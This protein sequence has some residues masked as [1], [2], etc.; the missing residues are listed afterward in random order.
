M[1]IFL[2]SP[3]HAQ[4][5]DDSIEKIAVFGSRIARTDSLGIAP[6]QVISADDIAQA[7]YIDIDSVLLELPANTGITLNNQ[8]NLGTT[9]SAS[10]V[11]LRGLGENLTLVL[12]NGLRVP[13]YSSAN[14]TQNFVNTSGIPTDALS[15][16]EVLT[17]GASAIYGSD[18]VSGVV[19]FVTNADFEGT[20]FNARHEITDDGGR[21]KTNLSV[22]YGFK[23][24]SNSTIVS[25]SYRKRAKLK[26]TDRLEYGL[27]EDTANGG[28]YSSFAAEVRDRNR[29]YVDSTRT[30]P[31]EGECFALLGEAGRYVDTLAS[32]R[33]TSIRCRFN[34]A[35]F[36]TIYPDTEQL[37]ISLNNTYEINDNWNFKTF[38]TYFQ[39]DTQQ[40]QEPKGMS[41]TVYQDGTNPENFSFDAD[42]F[43][44]TNRFSFRRRFVE[45][46]L[47]G[48]FIDDKQ[49]I[50]QNT[51]A[52]SIGD[53]LFDITYN[54]GRG[55]VDRNSPQVTF[56]G[57]EEILTFDPN[58]QDPAK[59]YPLNPISTEQFN[60]IS[61]RS[62]QK[63]FSELHQIQSVFTGD[64]P[65]NLGDEP[66]GFAI[67]A[68]IVDQ[69]FFDKKDFDTVNNGFVGFSS[70]QG[71]GG[72]TLYAIGAEFAIPISESVEFNLAG[73]YDYYDDATNVGGAFSPQVGFKYQPNSTFLLRANYTESFK[74][75]DLQRVHAG[76]TRLTSSISDNVLATFEPNNPNSSDSFRRVT[77]GTTDIKEE[78]SRSIVI[79]AVYA[80]TKNLEFTADYYNIKIDDAVITIDP[81]RI[82]LDPNNDLT[83]Q[84]SNCDEI[85]RV[86]F[87]T[88]LETEDDG[89]T[90][91]NLFQVC[92]GSVNATSRKA[93]GVDFTGRYSVLDTSAGDF[94]LS[95][96]TTWV[97]E[98]SQK[99]FSDSSLIEGTEVSYVPEWKSV[100]TLRWDH[101]NMGASLIWNHWGEAK[102]RN[103]NDLTADPYNPL[104][105]W[106]RVNFSA[107]YETDDLGKFTLGA[108]NILDSAPPKLDPEDSTSFP[109]YS[110][111]NGY[112]V[113]GRSFYLGYSLT[114]N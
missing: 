65:F 63:A 75:P 6:V 79:G 90:Y 13:L 40:D 64:L 18:A 34:R 71:G 44:S 24:D 70:T 59:W 28:N 54:Y 66:I 87:I 86:G 33:S 101:D 3:I 42:D 96:K 73:R 11:N 82:V 10:G 45:G 25:A 15:R 17:G 99:D 68:D 111:R 21:A 97:K 41:Q 84:V 98:R 102:G 14:G 31:T 95:S 56:A 83:G 91:R 43:E 26:A 76:I 2:A 81:D 50:I 32:G 109:F 113:V 4:D 47:G 88:T 9:R 52:G 112:N 100:T 94:S 35:Q 5:T 104:S 89:S 46:G 16:T 61:G 85:R 51:L 7:G 106:N 72:N 36:R 19:N 53:Y 55:D 80:P 110:R 23:T 60:Q 58:N 114:F 107:S 92:S 67:I 49:L 20:K 105:S 8:F 48:Q 29:I 108:N 39:K 69:K 27:G 22:K 12:L 30:T 38:I 62:E 1:P 103:E 78:S 77:K 93:S 74:A 37:N 57:L